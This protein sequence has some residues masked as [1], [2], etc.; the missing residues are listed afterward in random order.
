MNSLLDS[1]VIAKRGEHTNARWQLLG[2]VCSTHPGKISLRV[3]R[4][5]PS[6]LINIFGNRGGGQANKNQNTPKPGKRS[7]NLIN[8][9]NTSLGRMWKEGAE[10]LA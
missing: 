3:S 8:C 10:Q 2:D 5:N 9:I 6:Y 4:Y 1:V 7:F